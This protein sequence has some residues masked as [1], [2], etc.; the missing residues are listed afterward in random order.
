MKKYQVIT[1]LPD[2]IQQYSQTS[3]LGRGQKAGA[4]KIEAINLRDFTEDKHK[5][6]DD[7]PYGGGPGMILKPE[8]IF[9]AVESARPKK[10]KNNHVVLLDPRG[11]QFSQKIAQELTTY[12]QIIFIAGRYE[13]VDERVREHLADRT[14][15]IGPYVLTGG[16]LP[17]LIIIDAVARLIPG[18][19]GKSESLIQESF[20]TSAHTLEYPQY[21]KPEAYRGYKVPDILI[22]GNH[23]AINKWRKEHSK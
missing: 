20:S 17:A 7:S 23:A 3:I 6:V 2:I 15:S 8:P 5:T 18:V 13:G 19:L 22:S 11:E 21:T 4:I 16:E 10:S 1:V 9:K 14:I 12:E